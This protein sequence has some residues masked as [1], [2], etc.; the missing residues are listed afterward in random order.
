MVPNEHRGTL[1]VLVLTGIR[2]LGIEIMSKTNKKNFNY[3]CI[4]KSIL[5]EYELVLSLKKVFLDS[6][7]GG[8]P[9]MNNYFVI[10]ILLEKFQK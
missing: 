2:L 1:C 7:T 8:V 4:I 6:L 9:S 3:Y 10:N 5:K